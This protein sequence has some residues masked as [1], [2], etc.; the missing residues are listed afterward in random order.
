MAKTKP[1]KLEIVYRKTSELK[2]D[3]KNAR[4][5]S[6]G[7]IEQLRKAWRQFGIFSPIVLREDDVVAAGN[8]RLIMARQE[9]LDEVPTITRHGL[10][11][12][13]WKAFALAD[14]QIALNAGWDADALKT[15][16]IELDGANFD[17]NLTGFTDH[18]IGR[19]DIPNISYVA[20]MRHDEA[21]ALR[22]VVDCKDVAQ[23]AELIER[24]RKDG[25]VCRASPKEA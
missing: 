16:M 8:G 5:H 15:T 14:N 2:L 18:Q 21:P 23:Q 12:E 22:V 19:L 17:L 25:L 1:E 20:E 10:S 11:D 13:Q 3:P 7:Q 24:F 9:R 6:H 4:T